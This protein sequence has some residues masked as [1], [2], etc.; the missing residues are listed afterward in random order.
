MS[1]TDI[2]I[3]DYDITDGTTVMEVLASYGDT[4][5]GGADIDN[6]IAHYIIDIYKKESGIDLSKDNL[7]MQR[8]IDA[9]E[10]AK[11]ELSSAITTNINLP[12]IQIILRM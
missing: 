10:K 5:L 9:S 4:W 7:A 6:A 8:V 12:Y 2:S 3:I 11:I 1:T